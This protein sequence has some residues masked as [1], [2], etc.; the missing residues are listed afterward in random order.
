MTCSAGLWWPCKFSFLLFQPQ[1]HWI[2]E[3]PLH[4]S[5]SSCR[6]GWARSLETF[7]WG[8]YAVGIWSKSVGMLLWPWA[9]WWVCSSPEDQLHI[10]C[11]H[12]HHFFPQVFSVMLPSDTCQTH[13]QT[14]ISG[15]FLT[16]ILILDCSCF[17]GR[18]ITIF[19]FFVSINVPSAANK[20]TSQSG[21]YCTDTHVSGSSHLWGSWWGA[22]L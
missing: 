15:L 21:L 6:V 12:W 18:W 13:S 22:V 11:Q 9:G 2:E 16:P 1:S 17:S 20:Q 5:S 19:F 3:L 8:S 7:T 14:H 10:L 4:S